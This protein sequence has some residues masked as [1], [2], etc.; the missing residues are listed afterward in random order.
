MNLWKTL[1]IG[2]ALIAAI[3][4]ITN[5]V[6]SGKADSAVIQDAVAPVIAAAGL[7]IDGPLLERVI[8]FAVMSWAQTRSA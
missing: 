2:W 3:H 6:E 1:K 7:T 8:G 5:L 4:K